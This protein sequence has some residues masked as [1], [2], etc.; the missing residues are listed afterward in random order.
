[1]STFSSELQQKL[2]CDPVIIKNN[3]VIIKSDPIII[4]SHLV[5]II[6]SYPTSGKN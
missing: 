4:E 3:Q 6:K 2:T 1:M 5:V